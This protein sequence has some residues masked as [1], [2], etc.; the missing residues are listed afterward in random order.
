LTAEDEM[1][2]LKVTFCRNEQITTAFYA[3]ILTV[4]YINQ[5]SYVFRRKLLRK[6]TDIGLVIASNVVTKI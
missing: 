1:E 2:D 3:D 6:C 4:R 5:K